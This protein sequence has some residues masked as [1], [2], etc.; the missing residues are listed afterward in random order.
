M[1]QK[2]LNKVK[3]MGTKER[4]KRLCVLAVKETKNQLMPHEAIELQLIQAFRHANGEINDVL[5]NW[6]EHPELDPRLQG[7]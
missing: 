5:K 6:A 7:T 4:N 2:L 1:F 3:L